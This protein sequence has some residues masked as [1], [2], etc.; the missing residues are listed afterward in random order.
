MVLSARY[1]FS[2]TEL[3]FFQF[4]I[5]TP[6]TPEDLML[7][8]YVYRP[9]IQ[10]Y[11]EDCEARRQKIEEY[12]GFNFYVCFFEGR[13]GEGLVN[14]L[15]GNVLIRITLAWGKLMA[16]IG[17]VMWEKELWPCSQIE[18]QSWLQH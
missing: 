16:L 1:Q 8:Q 14:S 10:I 3:F 2:G 9:K 18:A 7:S 13:G 4:T 6:P 15:C 5:N 12:E 17:S 11:R